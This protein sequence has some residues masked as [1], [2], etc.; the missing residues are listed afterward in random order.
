M[1]S[2]FSNNTAILKNQSET[3]WFGSEGAN[4]SNCNYCLVLGDN[5]SGLRVKGMGC[6]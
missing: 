2:N 5:D 1:A 3:V 4:W 6:A